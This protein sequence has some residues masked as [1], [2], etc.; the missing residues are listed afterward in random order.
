MLDAITVP[1]DRDGKSYI[2]ITAANRGDAATT[3]TNLGF[4]AY[5]SWWARFRGRASHSFIANNPSQAQPI[6][7]FIEPRGRW[8]GMCIQNDEINALLDNGL[9]WAKVYA[10]HADKPTSVRLKRRPKP[11]SEKINGSNV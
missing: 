10:T 4:Q 7:H 11:K 1:R 6:P 5:P 8:M 2:V 9:L 3:I